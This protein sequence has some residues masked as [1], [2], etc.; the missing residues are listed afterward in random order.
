[1]SKNKQLSAKDKAFERERVK[2]HSIIQKK[3]EEIRRLSVEV[4]QYKA[5]AESWEKVAKLLE[6]QIGIPKEKLLANIE[7]NEKIFG[8]LNPLI[9]I[10][11]HCL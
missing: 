1:M 4:N 9:E 6:Q 2:L 7:R 10:G 11:K 5:Q 8:I 3:D